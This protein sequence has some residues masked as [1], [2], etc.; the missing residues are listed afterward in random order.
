MNTASPTAAPTRSAKHGIGFWAAVVAG[1]AIAGY[2]IAGFLDRYPDL[3]HRIS[4]ARW[5]VGVDLTHDLVL[6]PTVVIIGL[7]VRRI[8]PA[9]ALAPVQFAMM[10][11]GVVLLIAWRPLR[12]S[13]AYHHNATAQPLN[14]ATATLTVL[15]VIW[16]IA[17][18]WC[19][20]R[21]NG[22][23]RHRAGAPSPT[24]ASASSRDEDG[25]A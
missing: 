2:G 8:V 14:Y 20:L 1:G 16:T 22:H 23:H 25:D 7:V 24:P 4:L 3:S 15:A 21:G 12:G 9:R 18:T 10:A 19:L 5:I 11:S 13:A 6:A 17:A